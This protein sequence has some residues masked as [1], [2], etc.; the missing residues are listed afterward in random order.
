MDGVDWQM[1]IPIDRLAQYDIDRLL[2]RIGNRRRAAIR[3]N[4]VVRKCQP[5]SAL[6]AEVV[7]RV[8]ACGAARRIS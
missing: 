4:A 5:I 1:P 8:C 6:I 7:F 3:S 2:N